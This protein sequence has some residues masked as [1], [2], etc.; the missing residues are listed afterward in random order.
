MITSRLLATG[1]S[2]LALLWVLVISPATSVSAPHGSGPREQ[3]PD[4]RLVALCLAL[5][6]SV[7]QCLGY[8]RQEGG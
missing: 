4:P 2:L 6:G 5:G 8:F 3:Q 1:V 7:D